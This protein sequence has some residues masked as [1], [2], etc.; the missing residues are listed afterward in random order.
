MNKHLRI[1]LLMV[2]AIS[3]TGATELNKNSIAQ[4]TEQVQIN[5]EL[6]NEIL[7]ASIDKDIKVTEKVV[8]EWYVEYLDKTYGLTKSKQEFIYKTAK[9]FDLEYELVLSFAKVESNYDV[10]CET[11]SESND[12]GLFQVN[13]FWIKS[14][15]EKYNRKIDLH[16]FEDNTIVACDILSQCFKDWGKYKKED[17]HR[18]FLL[19][20]N[21]YNAGTRNIKKHYVSR[22]GNIRNREYGQ[23]I[24]DTYEAYLKGDWEFEVRD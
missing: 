23:M 16:D 10:K 5:T 11:V 15:S 3:L 14:M 19:S 20:V 7:V 22:G 13:K 8:D 24:E 12:V 21:S 18:Y 4:T 1:A 2:I 17:Q 9:N 6:R